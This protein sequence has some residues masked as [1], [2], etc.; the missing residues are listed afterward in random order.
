[1]EFRSQK[2]A[3]WY[4]VAALPLFL[5]QVVMG[6]WLAFNYTFT[7]PQAVVDVFPF[8]TARAFHTNLLVL[9]M[10]LGF[11]G[12]TYYVVPEE[13]QSEIFSPVLAYVQ[14][15]ALLLMGVTALAG[16][17]F[18][19]TKGR[20]LLEIPFP[21]NLVVVAGALIFLFNVGMTIFRAHRITV[22]QGTLLGGLV[23]L[24]GLY[25]F[26]IPFYRNLVIDWYYWWWVI[27]LWVEGAWE[28]VT[29][30]VMAFVL[31]KLTGVDR[32]V[33]E[34]WLYVEIGLFLF[35]GVAGTGHHY[36]W[37]GAPRYWLWVGGIFSALEP[38]PI[39]LMVVD[40]MHHVKAR[41]TAIVNPLVWTYAVG[42]S[43]L[44]LVGAGV[45]GFLH[46]LPQINYYT[47]GSQVTVS[48]GHLAFFGAYAMLNLT[49]FYFALPKLA[50]IAVFDDRR[51]KFGFWTMCIAMTV[52]GLT[53]G[54]SG[55]LQSYIERVL[56]M[57]YMVAQSY[58]RLWMGVT[59]F[60][61]LFFLAGVATTVVD[62]LTLRPA[63]AQAAG[64]GT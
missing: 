40:T 17:L 36:Y 19:W 51:G 29:G 45:W 1:M 25:L 49:V 47:H 58:M 38:L 44:H 8:A 39:V 52:M 24:A 30:A 56:G 28:L 32:E 61:G 54:V 23:F 6:L 2:I 9:W 18:G 5:L 50:G 60:A 35:T 53:F 21:L 34:K 59:L 7:V 20:P 48:H 33:V 62:L 41:R 27:H 31:M 63:P 14:L 57:G 15:V 4:F 3:Y 12:G 64:D 16:F 26:G 42:C 13:T 43:I 11:M 10:L 46:T 22:I 55:V 37:I